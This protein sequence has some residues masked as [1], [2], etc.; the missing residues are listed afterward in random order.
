VGVVSVPAPGESVCGDGWTVDRQANRLRALVVD[1]LGHGPGAY[2]AARAAMDQFAQHRG[3]AADDTL[4]RIHQ[5]I[6]HTRGAAASIADV[7]AGGE[8]IEF[9]GIGNVAGAVWSSGAL[10]Q[11]V[12]LNGTLGHTAPAP[13]RFTYPWTRESLLVMHSDG[14]TSHWSLDHSPGLTRRQ[15]VVVATVLLRDFS[16]GRDDVTVFVAREHA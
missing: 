8:A 9:A 14:L 15:P 2:D 4:A 11:M 16:R 5:G 12:R 13:R 10:R 6:R 7:R 1:G 3:A